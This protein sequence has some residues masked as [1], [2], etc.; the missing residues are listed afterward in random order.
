MGLTH[1]EILR[2]LRGKSMKT[3]LTDKNYVK[4]G[5]ACCPLCLGNQIEGQSIEVDGAV[6]WQ[7]VSCLDC[8]GEWQDIYK[9]AGYNLTA[10]G[11]KVAQ[12]QAAFQEEVNP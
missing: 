4:K 9:L 12:F 3:P 10:T 2:A 5:G 6:A 1:E 7:E 11:A 8:G